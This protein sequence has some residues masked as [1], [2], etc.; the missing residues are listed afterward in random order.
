MTF[1]MPTLTV[2]AFALS[3]LTA[4]LAAE[5]EQPRKVARIGFLSPGSPAAA[6]KLLEAFRQGLRELGWV[7][8]Q[9]IAIE[10]RFAEGKFERLPELAAELVALKVD[11]LVAAAPQPAR[12]AK[13][14]TSA[15][16]VVFIGVADPVRIGLISSLAR[17]GGN[18]TGVTTL[19]PGEFIA[20]Q[21]ELLKE[22]VPKASRLAVLM[23]PTNAV[24]VE[25]MDE[26]RGAA[27][28]LGLALQWLEAR[29]AGDFEGAF[30]AASGK[31]ADMLVVLGDPL[32]GLHRK[33]V[34]ELAAQHRLPAIYLFR[35]D[36]LAGGL[37]SYGPVLTDL[38][39][40]AGTYVDKILKGAKPADLAAEQPTKFE[41]LV[42][43]KTAKALGLSIPPSVMVRADQV[44][45]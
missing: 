22:T 24:H 42:N 29:A 40:R 13:E 15:I 1:T 5:A 12:A 14:A 33:R 8:G 20:K 31:R 19:V 3:L 28:K 4:P 45:E 32:V 7:E 11:L 10:W 17:P 36:V 37:M 21:V 25:R 43:L 23:N 16:P 18:V 30:Q 38:F 6:P 39:R 9:N 2:V 44:I 26:L 35:E 34:V 27:Q 41:L